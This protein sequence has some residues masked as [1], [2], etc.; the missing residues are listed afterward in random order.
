MIV[1]RTLELGATAF[2]RQ[3][4]SQGNY[5]SDVPPDVWATNGGNGL[6]RDSSSRFSRMTTETEDAG[7]LVNEGAYAQCMR[8]L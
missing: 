4:S 5:L 1:T 7:E 8:R 3:L 2:V 6:R